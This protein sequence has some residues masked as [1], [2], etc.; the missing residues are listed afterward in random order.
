MDFLNKD[1]DIKDLQDAVNILEK[2]QIPKITAGSVERL[3]HLQRPLAS[4]APLIFAM[5]TGALAMLLVTGLILAIFIQVRR[6]KKAA[7]KLNDPVMRYK[8]LLK[9]PVNCD[10]F[11]KLIQDA[12]VK[13]EADPS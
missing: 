6:H 4:N 9:D 11:V 3:R 8:E 13:G 1:T 5:I 7:R 10:A 2:M 12:N